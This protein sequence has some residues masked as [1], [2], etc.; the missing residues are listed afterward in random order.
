MHHR[1]C[2]AIQRTVV[3]AISPASPLAAA[4]ALARLAA[5]RLR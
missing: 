4:A 3:L 2:A 1:P 5:V